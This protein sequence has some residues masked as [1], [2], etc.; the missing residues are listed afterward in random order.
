MQLA[1]DSPL[2]PGAAAPAPVV[3]KPVAEHGA[4]PAGNPEGGRANNLGKLPAQGP[5]CLPVCHPPSTTDPSNTRY[6]RRPSFTNDGMRATSPSAGLCKCPSWLKPFHNFLSFL[7]SFSF[8]SSY[9]PSLLFLFLSSLLPLSSPSLSLSGF[10]Y[11]THAGFGLAILPSPP[12]EMTDM[13]HTPVLLLILAKVTKGQK[14]DGKQ[15]CVVAVGF[16]P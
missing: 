15:V 14:H 4:K 8:P 6:S 12:S 9:L 13:C 3:G 10:L 1:L 11:V 5:H 16:L 7:L 2:F